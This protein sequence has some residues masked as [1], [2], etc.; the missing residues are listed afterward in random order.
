MSENPVIPDEFRNKIG[1]ELDFGIHEIEKSMIRK[2][3]RA[4]DDSNPRWETAAPPTF[5]LSVGGEQFGNQVVMSMFPQGLLHGATELECYRPVKAGDRLKVSARY[6]L[7]VYIEIF[8]AG[9]I[10]IQ[11]CWRKWLRDDLQTADSTLMDSIN[12]GLSLREFEV[13]KRLGQFS[14]KIILYDEEQKDILNLI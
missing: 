12:K 3:A 7:E 6:F 5:I 11:N 10:L 1:A 4:I 2:F 9:I 13:A 8:I 14:K